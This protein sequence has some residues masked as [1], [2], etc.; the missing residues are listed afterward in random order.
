MLER[1]AILKN[2]LDGLQEQ[3]A[4][5]KHDVVALESEKRKLENINSMCTYLIKNRSHYSGYFAQ[6]EQFRILLGRLLSS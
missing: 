1:K 4:S 5:L 3:R 6:R 2:E